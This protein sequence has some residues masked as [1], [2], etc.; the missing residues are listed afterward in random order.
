M[1]KSKQNITIVTLFIIFLILVFLNIDIVV[2]S[3]IEAST[4]WLKKVFPTLFIMFIIQDFL[5]NYNF[6]YY[7]NR[8]FGFLF[9]KIFHF[10]SGESTAFI[11]S[12]I[13]GAPSNAFIITNMLSSNNLSIESANKLLYFTF[14]NNPLFLYSMLMLIFN[15]SY[16]TIKLIL[17]NYLTN[18]IIAFLFRKKANKEI[19]VK[20]VQGKNFGLIL[21]NS[22]KKSINTTIMIL[23]SITFFM[24]LSNIL[25]NYIDNKY[26]ALFIKMFLEVTQG[27]DFLS[28]LNFNSIIKEILTLITISFGGLSIHSQIYSLICDTKLKY[29]NFLKGRIFAIFISIILLSLCYLL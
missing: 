27:L 8:L 9:K 2:L 29:S 12:L 6:D 11:L 22:I 5:I 19:I 28:S 15:N 25:N 20:N 13:G 4:I 16:L 3:T 10:N 17:I 21:V 18:F 26:L 23:G 24:V 1:K 7:L 14:F